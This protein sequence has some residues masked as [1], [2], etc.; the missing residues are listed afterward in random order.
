M[1][2]RAIVHV[3]APDLPPGAVSIVGGRQCASLVGTALHQP[4]RAGPR[5]FST[6]AT[7]CSAVCAAASRRD[8]RRSLLFALTGSIGSSRAGGGQGLDGA[9]ATE[10]PRPLPEHVPQR[11]PQPGHAFRRPPAGGAGDVPSRCRPGRSGSTGGST[12]LFR[13]VDRQ[14]Q[15]PGQ[16]AGERG[17][18]PFAGTPRRHVEC[19]SHRPTGRR[20][21]RVAPPVGWTTPLP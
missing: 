11:V 12:A 8:P 10:R 5:P 21:D 6:G 13:E 7:R 16:K 19:R 4:L 9:R 14:P 2:V 18:Q 1:S 15:T 3:A 20:H 17:H